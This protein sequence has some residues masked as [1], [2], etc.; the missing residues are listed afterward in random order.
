MNF[1]EIDYN[2]SSMIFRIK[3]GNR[4]IHEEK[5]EIVS[6]ARIKYTIEKLKSRFDCKFKQ[7]S[8]SRSVEEVVSL[9][10]GSK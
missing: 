2:S 5:L 9:C 6:S 8:E 4:L 7:Y 1:I 10:R 3:D